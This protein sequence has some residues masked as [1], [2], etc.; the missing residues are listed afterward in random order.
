[1]DDAHRETT[2]APRRRWP[3]VLLLL[4]LG[5]LVLFGLLRAR[6]EPVVVVL[7]VPVP[8]PAP[9][10]A[11]DPEPVPAPVPEPVPPPVRSLAKAPRPATKQKA[12]AGRIVVGTV[13]G[14]DATVRKALLKAFRGALGRVDVVDQADSG[15][16]ITVIID[17]QEQSGDD[18]TVR[19]AASVAELPLKKVVASLKARADASGENTD[20]GEL[21][22]DAATACGQTLGKDVGAWVARHPP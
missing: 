7:P 11:A 19:C 2:D 20:V 5:L 3:L 13:T 18:V 21:M 14:G 6:P 15:Y 12:S 16:A 22:D 9:I 1:M 8:V 10:P 17:K 4:L